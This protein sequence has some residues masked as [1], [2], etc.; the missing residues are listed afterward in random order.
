MAPSRTAANGTAAWRAQVLVAH[1]IRALRE[2][3]SFAL[4]LPSEADPGATEH[5]QDLL[6]AAIAQARDA[7]RALARMDGE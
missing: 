1:G 3:Q 4:Q 5:I 7:Y 6:T 2:A